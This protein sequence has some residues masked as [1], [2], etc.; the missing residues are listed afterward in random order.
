[1]KNKK[2]TFEV[3]GLTHS[4]NLNIP[5]PNEM[6]RLFFVK[7]V[8]ARIFIYISSTDLQENLKLIVSLS[9]IKGVKIHL[10]VNIFEIIILEISSQ[11]LEFNKSIT[12]LDKD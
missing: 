4:L 10:K 8:K 2:M 7:K 11:D 6:D 3:N 5:N 12:S 1:M 9:Q